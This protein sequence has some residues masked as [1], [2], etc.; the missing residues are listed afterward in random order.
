MSD[1]PAGHLQ[2]SVIVPSWHDAENLAMLLPRLASFSQIS[3]V[4]VVDA[5]R[6]RESEKI[7][8]ET[9]TRFLRC[10]TPSRGAQMNFGAA[11][12]AGDVLV[13]QHSDTELT[14]AHLAA[15]NRTLEDASIIGGAFYRKFDGRHP[16]LMWLEPVARF[17]T[18]HGG[19]LFGDQTVFVRQQIFAQLGGYV[20]IPLMEDVEFSQRLRAAGK[21]AVLDPPVCTSARRHTRKGAWRA[22][23]QNGLFMLLYKLGVS[24]HALHHWYYR[25]TKI[26]A[27]AIVPPPGE[28][29]AARDL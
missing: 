3:E 12:A 11:A 8:V 20:A 6:D 7:A 25:E 14:E 13:F 16:R 21:V 23:L 29:I 2:I 19:T 10:G 15:L 24:P 5:S 28:A 9:G 26:S 4:I 18:K 1:R 17:F 22:S 27:P